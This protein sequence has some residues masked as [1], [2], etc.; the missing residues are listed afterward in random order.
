MAIELGN[1][2]EAIEGVAG[3]IDRLRSAVQALRD[4]GTGEFIQEQIDSLTARVDGLADEL[5]S[6]IEEAG[7]EPE[8]ETEEPPPFP[9]GGTEPPTA[10]QLPA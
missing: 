1:L 7:G 2:S 3:K 4:A 9:G 8:T 10:T 5:E 6:I